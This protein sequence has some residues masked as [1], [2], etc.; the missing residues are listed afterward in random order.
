MLKY[1]KYM[2][3]TKANIGTKESPNLTIIRDYWHD[4]ALSQIVNLLRKY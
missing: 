3:T 4:E 2:K 1:S